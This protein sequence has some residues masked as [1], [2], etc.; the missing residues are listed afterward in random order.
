MKWLRKNQPKTRYTPR[1]IT[2]D[3]NY[4]SLE[5]FARIVDETRTAPPNLTLVTDDDLVILVTLL[6]ERGYLSCGS[7]WWN[8]IRGEQYWCYKS[9]STVTLNRSMDAREFAA[10]A[11][12]L[13][14]IGKAL[15]D[16]YEQGIVQ[17]I[18]FEVKQMLLAYKKDAE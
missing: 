15:N 7:G 17:R 8:G 6:M 10:K 14:T 11:Y 3:E 9:G 12:A 16:M 13:E 5:D 18:R 4:V 2:Q 1:D